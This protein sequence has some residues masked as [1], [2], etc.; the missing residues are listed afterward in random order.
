[1]HWNIHLIYSPELQISKQQII[2][3]HIMQQFWSFTVS[4][5]TILA[6]SSICIEWAGWTHARRGL[7]LPDAQ[8]ST[9]FEIQ[10][11][12]FGS[13]SPDCDTRG[14]SHKIGVNCARGCT[15]A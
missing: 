1:M 5:L 2:S 14:A 12:V 10:I 9:Q 3:L 6:H 8:Y 15:Y 13:L 4:C 11:I 7:S